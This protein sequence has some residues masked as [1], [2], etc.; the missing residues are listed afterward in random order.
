MFK[1]S[2]A[3]RFVGLVELANSLVMFIVLLFLYFDYASSASKN[4]IETLYSNYGVIRLVM[5]G[6]ELYKLIIAGYAATKADYTESA[7]P[8]FVNS[9]I[10]TL[11]SCALFYFSLKNY[12]DI[13]ITMPVFV[14]DYDLT[15][16]I[17]LLVSFGADI[18]LM[19]MLFIASYMNRGKTVVVNSWGEGRG[20]EKYNLPPQQYPQQP[21]YTQPQQYYPQ[22]DYGQQGYYDENTYAQDGYTQDGCYDG[23][24]EQYTQEYYEEPAQDYYS[25]EDENGGV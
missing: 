4:M 12:L 10:L 7:M 8:L 19:I 11:S 18:L 5:V 23:T 21:Q 6:F 13:K 9:M 3:V 15:K 24:A 20:L 22:Q 14:P 2:K 16:E 1:G 25:Q 17:I